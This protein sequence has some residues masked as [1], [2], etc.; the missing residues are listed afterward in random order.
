MH[1][2]LGQLATDPA[3]LAVVLLAAIVAIAIARSLSSLAL[4]I[5][6]PGTKGPDPTNNIQET[7]Q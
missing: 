5:G 6:E 4:H 7:E 2:I 1:G 3:R